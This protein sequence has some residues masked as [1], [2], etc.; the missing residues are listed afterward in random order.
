MRI[1]AFRFLYKR[2]LK[3]REFAFDNVIFP[4]VP[5]KPRTVLSQEEVVR[6]IE[7]APNRL[8]RV[9]LVPLYAT[10]T[11]RAQIGHVSMEG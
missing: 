6:L 4:K 3:Q 8:Y 5:H 7:A 10:G 9:L 2:T 11:R 1:S